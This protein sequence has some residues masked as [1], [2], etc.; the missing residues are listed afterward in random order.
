MQSIMV[1]P[2]L[3]SA[4]FVGNRYNPVVDFS[5]PTPGPLFLKQQDRRGSCSIPK[6]MAY[7]L[8][9]VADAIGDLKE[10]PR[11]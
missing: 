11:S 3:E 2:D 9:D 5:D 7:S 8:A 10:R 6:R 1:R 4:I